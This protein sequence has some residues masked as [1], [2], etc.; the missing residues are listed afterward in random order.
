MAIKKK[1]KKIISPIYAIFILTVAIILLS[2]IFS[3]IG[4]EGQ[5]AN[6]ISIRQGDLQYGLEM[7]LVTVRNALSMEGL[8]FLI[9]NATSNLNIFSPLLMLIISLIG[10][11]I[12]ESSGLFKLWFSKLKKLKLNILTFITLLITIILTSFGQYVFLLTIPF[13][14]LVYKYSK[15]SPVLGVLV[16]FIGTLAGYGTGVM[17]DY[18]NIL[19]GEFTEISANLE[20][21]TNYS[22]NNLSTIFIA[23]P[24]VLIL[25][26][27]GTIIVDKMLVNKVKKIECKE[28]C[29]LAL[30][31]ENKE[32]KNILIT[33]IVLFGLVLGFLYSLIPGLPF[34][35]ALLDETQPR[36]IMM[37]MGENSMFSLGYIYIFSL[38]MI[39]TGFTYGMLTGKYKDNHDFNVGLSSSFK[40]LGY[41]FVVLFFAIQMISLF[42]WTNIGVVFTTNLIERLYEFQ[43]SGL[44]M[45]FAFIIVVFLATLVITD[46]VFKWELMSPLVVPLFMRSNVTPDFTQFIFRSIEGVSRGF[47]PLFIFLII[48]IGFIQKHSSDSEKT[49]I[50]GTI[51]LLSPA[52]FAML[53]VWILIIIVWYLVGIPIGIGTY[54]TI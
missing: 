5:R 22:F 53:G 44:P 14:A 15:K 1:N 13:F 7:S 37:L 35:G 54:P 4:L 36:Y 16:A 24:S 32:F 17:L 27:L 3:L 41:L 49:T 50:F 26:I 51:K 6:I 19:L 11:G 48:M 29:E 34:S 9:N 45:I 30:E 42:E 28:E 8:Y 25:S 46:P 39:A 38:I 21:I 10:I 40:D 23:I 47:T 33:H 18:E 43:L 2:Y 12:G 52:L 20:I 31:E